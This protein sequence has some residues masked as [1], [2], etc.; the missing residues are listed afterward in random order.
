[1]LTNMLTVMAIWS[2]DL[3]KRDDLLSGRTNSTDKSGLL[4]TTTNFF[5]EIHKYRF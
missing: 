2:V 1:M 5:D 4:R 3:T